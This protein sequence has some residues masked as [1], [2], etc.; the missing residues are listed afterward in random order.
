MKQILFALIMLSLSFGNAFAQNQPNRQNREQWAKEFREFKH[1]ALNKHLNLTDEQ[2]AA[3]FEV[4]DKMDREIAKLNRETRALERKI[5][6]ADEGTVTDVEYEAATNAIIELK[7]KECDIEKS[8]YEEFKKILTPKQ[9]FNLKKTE[10]EF[11]MDMMRQHN[12]LRNK[13]RK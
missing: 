10:R 9:L 3:F 12:K 1:E 8:Y 6:K 4:Y 11:S 5:T 2:K 7:G 13:N